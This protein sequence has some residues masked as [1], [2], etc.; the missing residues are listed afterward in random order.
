MGGGRA[1]EE[2][3]QYRPVWVPRGGDKANWG[4][5]GSIWPQIRSG[6]LRLF[7]KLRGVAFTCVWWVPRTQDWN[8]PAPPPPHSPGGSYLVL[9]HLLTSWPPRPLCTDG[10]SGGHCSREGVRADLGRSSGRGAVGGRVF[11]VTSSWTPGGDCAAAGGG[12]LKEDLQG[13]REGAGA[14]GKGS[15][16][17]WGL[18]GSRPGA[19]SGEGGL[20][21]PC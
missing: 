16:C 19:G 14:T 4:G 10:P 2:M 18:W 11:R 6:C 3:G 15:Q 9:T 5:V 20:A 1:E 7:R 17:G 21:E 8:V 13:P 12:A